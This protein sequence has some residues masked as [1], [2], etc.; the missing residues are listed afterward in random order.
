[1]FDLQTFTFIHAPS[2]WWPSP[3]VSSCSFGLIAGK[4]PGRLD[5]VFPGD[6]HCDERDRIRIPHQRCDAGNRHR[7]DIPGFAGGRPLCPLRL[8][9]RRRLASGLCHHRGDRPVS[10]FLR[11]DRTELSEGAG[12]QDAGANAIRAALCDRAA[13]RARGVCCSWHPGSNAVSRTPR[14][15]RFDWCPTSS[16]TRVLPQAWPGSPAAGRRPQHGGCRSACRW[17]RPC[18]VYGSGREAVSRR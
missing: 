16:G 9:S 5:G 3:R 8:P 18:G 7:R 4:R 2:A 17:L 14:Q 6:H 11:L 15:R 1:M 13:R 12:A 10:Q